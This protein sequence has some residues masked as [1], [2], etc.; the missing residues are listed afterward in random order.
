MGNAELAEARVL[1]AARRPDHLGP[2][3]AA[4][5]EGRL[6]DSSRRGMNEDALALRDVAETDEHDPGRDVVD[7][8][9][10]RL[11]ERELVR[12]RKGRGARDANHVAVASEARESE[13]ARSGREPLDTGSETVDG[14]GDLV[15]HDRRE[16]RR[17]GVEAETSHDVREVDARGRDADAHLALAGLRIG[18]LANL[19]NLGAPRPRNPDLSHARLRAGFYRLVPRGWH[20][21]GE[22]ALACPPATNTFTP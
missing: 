9:R 3:P 17:V 10:G 6:A 20:A 2:A 12:D 18:R 13:D 8:D 16:R 5:L 21:A 7:R 15:A 22:Q 4:D 14:A 1:G 19:E 11:L